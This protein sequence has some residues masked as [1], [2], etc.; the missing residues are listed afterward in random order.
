MN[1]RNVFLISI[2]ST[3]ALAGAMLAYSEESPLP[4]GLTVILSLAALLFN[5]QRRQWHLPTFVANVLGLAALGAAALEFRGVRVDARLLAG[6]HI[7]V[8]ITW[9]V[10][11]L[12]KEMR[13]YWWL[14]ALSLLQVALGPLLT[15]STGWYGLLLLVYLCLAIWTLAVFTLYQGAV[16][17]GA[18]SPANAR[19]ALDRPR[20]LRDRL[21][22]ARDPV[23]AFRAAFG[24]TRR[25]VVCDAVQQDS[26][27]QWLVPRFVALV[28]GLLLTGFTLGLGLFLFVPRLWIG[29]GL[30]VEDDARGQGAAVTGYT[31]QV[32]LGQ[33]GQIL[34][35]NA[36]V[37]VVELFDNDTNEPLDIDEFANRQGFP[38]PLFRGGVLDRYETGGWNADRRGRRTW[39][40]DSRPP[41][42]GMVRQEYTLE[43]RGSET[44]FAIP[45]FDLAV[46][47]S[48][49]AVSVDPDSD[50]LMAKLEGHDPFEYLVYCTPRASGENAGERGVRAMLPRRRRRFPQASESCRRLPE[51]G[52]ERLV[53]LAREVAASE[54]LAGSEDLSREHRLALTLEAYLRDSGKYAY[55]LDMSVDDPGID[56][57]EDFLFNRRRGHCEYFASSLALMLRAVE[58][59]SRLVTG[60]KGA[61]PLAGRG[62]YQVQQR[63]AHAWVEAF[64][65]GRWFVLDPTPPD[66]D[67]DVRTRSGGNGFWS[68]A[69]DSISSLW[70]NYVVSLSLNRQQQ[71]LYDPL[72]GSVANGWGVVRQ[73]LQ[74]VAGGIEELKNALSSP[75]TLL[76]PRG[77]ILSLLAAAAG[78]FIYRLFRRLFD[79]ER[80]LSSHKGW[81]RGWLSR[82]FDWLGMRL[83]GRSPDPVRV[84][85]AFYERFQGLAHIAGLNPRTDQ[86][87]REFARDVEAKLGKRLAPAGLEKFPSELAELFYRVRF[88]DDALEP[89]ESLAVED[90]LERLRVALVARS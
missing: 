85:V 24:G 84:V 5:E 71:A 59:P 76:S 81:R 52:L 80:P 28:G 86:T 32:K 9:I 19:P 47:E 77:A 70:T 78:V 43:L 41:K 2:Y 53:N 57:V 48:Q 10:L 67:I 44:L 62:R 20:E 42:E 22:P 46:S 74:R 45:G 66:R 63:H 54:K 88:G 72:H 61:D 75:E 50:V 68:N 1:L 82:L 38:G 18:V 29:S 60:F 7:L 6:A 15:L 36:R 8:Y 49:Q 58:I 11:F 51:T 13:H 26:P 23:A 12:A 3:T 35:S 31:D 27:G 17:F 87:Q 16:D 65:G 34:E 40:V 89:A 69:R 25:G 64:V 83:A 14:C 30:R 79:R 21:E 90:R 56:P 39:T 4:S 55:S 33:I 37:M 73:V